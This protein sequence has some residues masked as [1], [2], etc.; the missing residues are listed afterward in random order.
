MYY[1][2]NGALINQVQREEAFTEH[3]LTHISYG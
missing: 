3:H 2:L 1:V